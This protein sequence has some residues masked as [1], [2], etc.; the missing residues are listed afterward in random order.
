MFKTLASKISKTLQGLTN[1]GTINENSILS[2]ISE[3]RSALIDADVSLQVVDDFIHKVKTQAI[4]SSVLKG[5][6]QGDQFTKILHDE[7]VNTLSHSQK[8]LK[9]SQKKPHVLAFAGLQGAGKTTSCVKLAIW[10]AQNQNLKTAIASVDCHR[11]AAIDQLETLCNDSNTQFIDTRNHTHNATA[12]AKHAI[13]VGRKT[14][15]DVIILDLAGRHQVDES[16]MSEAQSVIKAAEVDQ[17]LFTIDSMLGQS[18]VDVAKAFHEA[19]PLSGIILT[20][21][22]ADSKGGAAL[23]TKQVTG[24]P[25]LFIGNGEKLED[26]DTFDP[27]RIAKRILDM[28][29]I[30]SLVREAEKHID[31]KQAQKTATKFKS[32]QF[33]FNDFLVQL[34]QLKKMG[35]LS[36]IADML[37]GAA[38]M[39][40]QLKSAIDED[41]FKRFEAAIRSMCPDERRHPDLVKQPSRTRRIAKGSGLDEKEIKKLLKKFEKMN[42]QMKKF[43][44]DKMRK[45]MSQFQDRMM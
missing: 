5:V 17:V 19:L 33:D 22:D 24:L 30:V 14:H 2:A 38:G 12:M 6:R 43:S 29:D 10:L 13:S 21:M 45:L 20:K 8:T 23:S 32:G 15:A 1:S 35:G 7:L 25:I 36:K 26:F 44:G 3:I 42:K 41:E 9:F 37:P 34:E 16:L 31:K 11:P 40:E 39:S 27:E 4:G 28:G 18:A